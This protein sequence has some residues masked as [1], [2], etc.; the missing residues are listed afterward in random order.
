[1]SGRPRGELV[2]SESERE[3]LQA[4]TDATQDRAGL[5]IAGAHRVACADGMDNRQLQRNSGSLSKR[6]RSGVRGS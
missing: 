3:E 2:L 1:M 5:G 6:F 4:L